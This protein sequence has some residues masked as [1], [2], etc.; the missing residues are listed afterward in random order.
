MKYLKTFENYSI[1]EEEEFLK[2]A[3]QKIASAFGSYNDETRKYAEKLMADYVSDEPLGPDATQDEVTDQ[4]QKSNPKVMAGRKKLVDQFNAFKQA[5]DS[6]SGLK[7]IEGIVNGKMMALDLDASQVKQ[8]FEDMCKLIKS[9]GRATAYT[10]SA[11]EN[12]EDGK[13]TVNGFKVTPNYSKSTFRTGW[14][15]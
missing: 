8:M 1:N 12:E 3:A 10:I 11:D 4:I 13:M 2:A 15:G 7:D 9:E 6:K 14:T 5:Y